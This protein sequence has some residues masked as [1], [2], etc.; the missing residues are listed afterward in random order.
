MS[1]EAE[2][3]SEATVNE[4]DKLISLAENVSDKLKEL[5][6]EV[7]SIKQRQY[8]LVGVVYIIICLSLSLLLGIDLLQLDRVFQVATSGFL[9]IVTIPV[10]IIYTTSRRRILKLREDIEVESSVLKELLDMIHELENY[11]RFIESIDPVT[12][13]TY[14]MR[15]KRLRFSLK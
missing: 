6:A 2:M 12:I 15:L 14:R 11:G 3:K 9:M 1:S 5:D 7:T 13:A 10:M 4:L 8:W